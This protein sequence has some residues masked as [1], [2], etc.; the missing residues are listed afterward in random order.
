MLLHQTK[1]TI[2]ETDFLPPYLMHLESIVDFPALRLFAQKPGS[3]AC[4]IIDS[5]GGAGQMILEEILVGLEWR[6]QTIFGAPEPTFYD[7]LPKAIEKNMEPLIFNVSVT[8]ALLGI[9]TDGDAEHF[10]I[11]FEDGKC[12]SAKEIEMAMNFK[13]QK[14]F[15]RGYLLQYDGLLAGLL[16]AEMIAMTEKSLREIVEKVTVGFV[17]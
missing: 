5:M 14:G 12:M 7:R 15:L 9:A 3:N 6:A 13:I 8:D 17:Q 10:S 16:F 11:T 1:G 4:V 2:T